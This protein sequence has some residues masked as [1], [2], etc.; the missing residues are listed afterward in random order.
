MIRT[1][2]KLSALVIVG[3]LGI[4]CAAVGQGRTL[5]EQELWGVRG[6][7]T[8]WCKIRDSA[9]DVGIWFDCDTLPNATDCAIGSE[10]QGGGG[11]YYR[12]GTVTFASSCTESGSLIPCKNTYGCE[13]YFTEEYDSGGNPIYACQRKTRATTTIAS[14]PDNQVTGQMCS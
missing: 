14:Y 12:C 5:T 8:G 1:M 4:A 6:A 13:W 3:I 10:Q 7:T 9:C 2:A 11:S